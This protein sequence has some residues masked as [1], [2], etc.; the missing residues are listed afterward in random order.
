M[1]HTLLIPHSTSDEAKVFYYKMAGDYFRYQ[2]EYT[3]D[4]VREKNKS[5]AEKAYTH[6]TDHATSLQ[7]TDPIR[8]GLALNFSV[9][10]EWGEWRGGR[11]EVAL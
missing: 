1:I 10:C 8:L 7:A 9:F 6:A 2:A 3:M 5:E 4:A 11:G